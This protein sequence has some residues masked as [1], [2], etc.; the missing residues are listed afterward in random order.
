[1][2]ATRFILT[3]ASLGLLTAAC[4]TPGMAPL[5][6]RSFASDSGAYIIT[7]GVDTI[8]VE[9]FFIRGN[10]LEAEATGRTPRTYLQR[11][12]L[13]WDDAGRVTSYEVRVRAPGWPRDSVRTMVSYAFAAD[14]ITVTRRTGAQAPTTS[15]LPNP[16][17]IGVFGLP[18]YSPTGVFARTAIR[19][20]DTIAVALFG[21]S[22]LPMAVSTVAPGSYSFKDN[23]LG[24]IVVNMDSRG[25]VQSFDSRRSTLGNQVT[26]V[27]DIDVEGWARTFAARDAAGQGLGILSPP[28]TVRADVNGANVSITYQRPSKRGRTIFGGVVPWDAVWRTGANTATVFTTDRNLTIGGVAVPT[29]SYT[30]WSIPSRSGWQ[31]VINK[32]TGQWGTVYNQDR[33]LAR[34]PMTV[35]RVATPVEQFTLAI[36]GGRLSLAWD[37][38][39]AWV[40]ITIAP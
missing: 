19:R 22:G 23:G 31:L 32:Q 18:A 28:D 29:G 6:A 21:G 9:K 7:L 17:V 10:T 2:R 3:S 40:P 37:D 34:I 38:T 24:T 39:R 14:S 26:R 11:M 25:R 27:S 13:S 33:D 35:E 15:K 1:M 30:L 5:T 8:A 16:G 12:Q 4:A 36:A 20:G